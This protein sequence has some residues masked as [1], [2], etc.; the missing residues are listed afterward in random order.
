MNSSWWLILLTIALAAA[1]AA[2]TY[3]C[4]AGVRKA[5]GLGR[6]S[7]LLLGWAFWTVI[8]SPAAWVLFERADAEASRIGSNSIAIGITYGFAWIVCTFVGPLAAYLSA[9]LWRIFHAH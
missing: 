9:S 6:R 4:S 7:S 8:A 1:G 5:T 2:G 3:L